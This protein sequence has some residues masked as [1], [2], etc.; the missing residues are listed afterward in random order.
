[1][2]NDETTFSCALFLFLFGL[3]VENTYAGGEG[4]EPYQS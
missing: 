2:P 3:S 4:C 1:M